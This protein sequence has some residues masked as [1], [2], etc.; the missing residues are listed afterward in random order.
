MRN[1]GQKHGMTDQ[2]VAMLK[3]KLQD[4]FQNLGDEEKAKFNGLDVNFLVDQLMYVES[5]ESP[6]KSNKKN[7]NK[8]KSSKSSSSTK[9]SST[10][11]FLI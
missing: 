2:I 1:L 8:E 7:Q 3:G 11:V 5:N 6:A 4:W 10:R 9:D